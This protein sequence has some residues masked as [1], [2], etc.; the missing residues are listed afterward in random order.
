MGGRQFRVD[1]PAG[2]GLVGTCNAHGYVY[3][4]CAVYSK[5]FWGYVKQAG[6]RRRYHEGHEPETPYLLLTENEARYVK[7]PITVTHTYL[8]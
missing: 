2:A 8:Y 5:R 1:Q 7:Y 3:T 4:L 6:A